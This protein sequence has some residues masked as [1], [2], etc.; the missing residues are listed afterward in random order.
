MN[1][2]NI[3]IVVIRLLALNFLLQGAI[4]FAPQLFSYAAAYQRGVDTSWLLGLAWITIVGL[5]GSAILLWVFSV[6]IAGMVTSDVPP[7]FSIGS[8]TLADCYSIAFMGV[9]LGLIGSHFSG[10]LTW[11]YYLIRMASIHPAETW[12]EQVNWSN[13]LQGFVPFIIGIILFVNGRKWAIALARRQ[14]ETSS[15]IEPPN[16]DQGSNPP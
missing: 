15:P 5:I 14:A 8:L 3:V 13:V 16:P 10:V 9:G 6:F 12:K 2:K 11:S 4:Q 1:L 7:E